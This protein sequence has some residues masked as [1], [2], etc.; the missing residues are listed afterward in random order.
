MKSNGRFVNSHP[1]KI[2]IYI[3]IYIN[4]KRINDYLFPF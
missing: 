4:H 3:Y 2:Y 1:I